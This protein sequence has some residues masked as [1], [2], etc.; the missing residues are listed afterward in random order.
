M[1]EITAQAVKALSTKT[2]LPMMDVKK[3]LVEANGD[4]KAAL[5]ILKG[6]VAKPTAKGPGSAFFEG[7]IRV[8]TKP[9]GSAAAMVELRC[10]SAPV[11]T[12]ED[13]LFLADQCAKQLLNGPGAATPDDLL[14]QTA[15]DKPGESLQS[16]CENT[17]VNKA[18]ER[19]GLA[20]I[21]R[22]IG[23]V[24]AYASQD[25]KTGVLLRASGAK[26]APVLRDVAMQIA[27]QKP[28]VANPEELNA[29]DVQRERNRLSQEAT[30]SGKPAPIV[31]KIVDGRMNAYY[32]E[33]GVLTYQL[34]ANDNAKTVGQALAESG[35]KAEQFIRWQLGS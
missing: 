13:F 25:G 20:R 2:N 22:W 17:V 5:E 9:D 10:E 31:A 34:F 28:L 4:E 35:L 23:P 11:A 27:A 7:A 6:N 1:A 14:K 12:S 26:A 8:A 30:A 32:A 16:L 24:A 33:K 15:P 18:R 21:L 29:D 3:A 19:V